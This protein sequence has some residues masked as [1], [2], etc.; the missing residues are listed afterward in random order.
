[1]LATEAFTL[2]YSQQKGDRRGVGVTLGEV[3]WAAATKETY[4]SAHYKRLARTS[5]KNKAVVAV[6]HTMLV[7]MYHMIKNRTPYKE[8]GEEYFNK[9]DKE[10]LAKNMVKRLEKLGYK[11]EIAKEEED[12]AA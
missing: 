9:I 4:L 1:M 5:G 11:I 8:L 12:K 6:G 7:I 10:K 2:P 3:A